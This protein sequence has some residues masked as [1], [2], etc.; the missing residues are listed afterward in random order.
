MRGGGGT[1]LV[2]GWGE[3]I[4]GESSIE[5]AVSRLQPDKEKRLDI[6]TLQTT[7]LPNQVL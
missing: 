1:L 2:Q 3:L 7:P 5:H 6:G 4:G